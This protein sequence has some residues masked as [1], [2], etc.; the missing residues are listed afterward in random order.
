[1]NQYT[2]IEISEIM[3]ENGDD[4]IL[5]QTSIDAW[6]KIENPNMDFITLYEIKAEWKE[7]STKVEVSV[8]KQLEDDSLYG[9]LEEL[10]EK[11]IEAVMEQIIKE[12]RY[13]EEFEYE[14]ETKEDESQEQNIYIPNNRDCS[15]CCFAF[16]YETGSVCASFFYGE[17]V[18]KLLK[19]KKS[20]NCSG[21]KMTFK[22]FNQRL[23][24]GY[25]DVAL[26]LEKQHKGED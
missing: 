24:E 6:T 13:F 23:R 14:E 15:T 2:D 8:F 9:D 17:S 3:I 16:E 25:D 18:D 4:Y 7:N 12:I 20:F 1:M 19:E 26:F 11:G 21:W 5:V 22:E 10:I